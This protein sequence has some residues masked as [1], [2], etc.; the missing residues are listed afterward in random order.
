[1]YN[2]GIKKRCTLNKNKTLFEVSGHKTP[3]AR[4][5]KR[6]YSMANVSG[7]NEENL[8]QQMVTPCRK[9][10]RLANVSG[11]KENLTPARQMASQCRK[12]PKLNK[13]P[14]SKNKHSIAP[15]SKTVAPLYTSEEMLYKNYVVTT[16][17]NNLTGIDATK[18]VPPVKVESERLTL[19]LDLDKTL[20][21]ASDN[22]TVNNKKQA[23]GTKLLFKIN[24][25]TS[26]QLHINFRPFLIEFLN[27]AAKVF[28]LIFWTAGKECYGKA[29]KALF[30]PTDKYFV[31]SFYNKHC[32]MIKLCQ[33]PSIL[34]FFKAHGYK[35]IHRDRKFFLKPLQMIGRK[36]IFILDD[37]PLAYGFNWDR[38]LP[39]CPYNGDL[40]DHALLDLIPLMRSFGK[41]SNEAITNYIKEKHG[42]SKHFD[43]CRSE[44]KSIVSRVNRATAM[45]PATKAAAKAKKATARAIAIQAA[46]RAKV[47][48]ARA[49]ATKAAAEAKKATARAVAIQAATRA[50]AIQAAT[51]A[52]TKAKTSVCSPNPMI[53]YDI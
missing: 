13:A 15:R 10:R 19:V 43:K 5:S 4:K 26:G 21:K 23:N 11:N 6:T 3:S 1:M 46:T 38:V 28:D 33:D 7:N 31:N 50:A 20:I 25:K 40:N 2:T 24:D 17:V 12:A 14:R 39:I 9:T 45:T 53:V 22:L 34:T 29:V 51:E 16:I 49:A 8:T 52:A 44:F 27:E 42:M 48:A 47:A 35:N 18:L 41:M 37:S 30:D 36:N 32:T